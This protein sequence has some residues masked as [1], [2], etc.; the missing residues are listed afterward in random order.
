M[1]KWLCV[2][3]ESECGVCAESV[4]GMCVLCVVCCGVVMCGVGA[5]VG[6]QCVFNMRAFC[7][8]TRMRFEPTHGDVLNQHTGTAQLFKRIVT[9][10]CAALEVRASAPRSRSRSRSLALSLSHS[11]SPFPSPPL[12]LSSSLLL[13]LSL[14]SLSL[15][16]HCHLVRALLLSPTSDS[17]SMSVRVSAS[18]VFFTGTLS[19][20]T[21][22]A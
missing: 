21:S 7:R 10:N 12:P 5:G 8:Y 16:F 17:L 14:P 3:V 2:C 19:Y 22:S 15:N 11:A 4:W 13:L 18:L 9:R 1:L 20:S 6:V